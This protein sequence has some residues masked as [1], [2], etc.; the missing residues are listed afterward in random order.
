M[1]EPGIRVERKFST[2]T[3]FH[4]N[5]PVLDALFNCYADFMKR[6]GMLDDEFQSE[7][8]NGEAGMCAIIL[9]KTIDGA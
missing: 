6:H 8:F 9:T 3:R 7:P 2:E 5:D 4:E 1:P